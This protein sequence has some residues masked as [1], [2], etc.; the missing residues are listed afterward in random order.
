MERG[1]IKW[2]AFL[3]PEA[4]SGIN[5]WLEEDKHEERVELFEDEIEEINLA[6]NEAV[7]TG[8][9]IEIKHYISHLKQ[10]TNIK[11]N[12]IKYYPE[13]HCIRVRE[14]HYLGVT[15][16]RIADIAAAWL[17]DEEKLHDNL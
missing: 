14:L 10:H 12:I 1:L 11:C 17:I 2:G 16:I 9:P 15:E 3:M 5:K 8:S 6:I 7:E 13:R 4:T